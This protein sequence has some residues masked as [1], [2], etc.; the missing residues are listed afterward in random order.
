MKWITTV[1]SLI[2]FSCLMAVPSFAQAPIAEDTH[3]SD[4]DIS[5][6]YALVV[7]NA[8]RR[9]WQYPVFPED[10]NIKATVEITIAEDGKILSS[11]LLNSSDNSLF[12][13]SVLHAIRKTEFVAKPINERYRRLR[14][15]FNSQ[16]TSE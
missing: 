11:K 7:A 9:H 3:S 2:L 4:R 10:P 6:F 12:D 16:E 8:I 5:A 1:S 14:I 15:I 13:Y